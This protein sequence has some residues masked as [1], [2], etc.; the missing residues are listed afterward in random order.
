MEENL[1][2]SR[3]NDIA[4]GFLVHHLLSVNKTAVIFLHAYGGCKEEILGL[5]LNVT[6][7]ECDCFVYDLPG[8]GENQQIFNLENIGD[9]IKNII[10][11]VQNY[12]SFYLV[13]H[14]MGACIALSIGAEKVAAISP[15]GE[16]IFEGRQTELMQ[17][18]RARRVKEEIPYKGLESALSAYKNISKEISKCLVLYAKNDVRSSRENA[19][20]MAG[21]KNFLVKK[22][23]ASNH[24]DIIT[25]SQTIKEVRDF[26]VKSSP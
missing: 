2:V 26:L 5:A 14:S 10:G 7:L 17:I 8:H 18:I 15:P 23:N 9:F 12:N 24:L 11:C 6:N 19:L 21:Y 16:I 20:S 1:I 22:I 13:G 25:S 4:P 3:I